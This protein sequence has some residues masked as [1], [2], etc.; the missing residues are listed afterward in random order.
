MASESTPL[1]DPLTGEKS[2]H[3]G[4]YKMKVLNDVTSNSVEKFVEESV[5]PASVLFTD[6]NTAYV[7][8]E[9]MVENQ[10]KVKFSPNTTKWDLNW[11]HVAIS[12]LKK[13]L[14]GI[15]HMVNEKYLR[16]Y[17]DEFLY[18]LIRRYF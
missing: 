1:E 11:V 13:I 9:R 4:F 17:I 5:A 12:K 2:R 15:Y 16:N 7:N 8:I 6:K 18:I 10:I 14:L 3:C